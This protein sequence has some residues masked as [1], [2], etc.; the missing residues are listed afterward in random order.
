MDWDRDAIPKLIIMFFE[1]D[2]VRG[3]ISSSKRH[4]TVPEI[5][6]DCRQTGSSPK[7][8]QDWH[9][10]AITKLILMFFGVEEVN[11]NNPNRNQHLQTPEIQDGG[12]Q[13]GN[14][15]KSARTDRET[16]FQTNT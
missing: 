3:T 10:E 8:A 15:D 9:A 7:S 12:L 2:E 11:R 13:T 4:S 5:Q 1:V 14:S 16:R 6:D